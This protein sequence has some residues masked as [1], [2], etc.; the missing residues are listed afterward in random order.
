[1]HVVFTRLLLMASATFL[2]VSP[3]LAGVSTS[4]ASPPSV[5]A[6][7]KAVNARFEGA[8]VESYGVDGKVTAS[9]RLADDGRVAEVQIDHAKPALERAMRNTLGRLRRLPPMPEGVDH[10]QRVKVQLLFD[11]GIDAEAYQ[12]K[13]RAMLAEADEVNRRFAAGA[14]ETRLALSTAR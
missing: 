5:A 12:S 9:F 8:M 2:Y 1:M 11:D 10:H 14:I 6:W 7:V 4:R 3:L 13:R